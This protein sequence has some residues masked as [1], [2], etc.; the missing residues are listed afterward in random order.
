MKPELFIAGRYIAARKSHNIINVISGISA[1]GLAVGTAALVAILSVY[2][3]FDLLVR[4]AMGSIE[5]DLLVQATEGKFF[6]IDTASLRPALEDACVSNVCPVVAEDVY[7]SYEGNGTIA[8]V[9]GVDSVFEQESELSSRITDGVFTLHRSGAPMACLGEALAFRMGISPRFLPPVELYFPKKDVPFSITA[10]G[11]SIG[12]VKVWPAGIFS[13]GNEADEKLV[14]VPVETMR[15][16]LSLGD[17]MVSGIEIRFRDES[18][19]AERKSLRKRLETSLGPGYAVKDR[20][21]QNPSLYRMMKYEKLSIYMILAFVLAIVA[22]NIFGSLTMLIIEK[23]GDIFT[24]NSFGARKSL[25]RRIFLFEGWGVSMAGVIAGTVIGIAIVFLQMKTGMLKM[26]GSFSGT[27]YPVIL[28]VQD[29]V[30]SLATASLIGFVTAA[31][32]ALRIE[33]SDKKDTAAQ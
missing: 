23:E 8:T 16:L 31:I 5:P 2:N 11:S 27:P 6:K 22:F 13:L 4:Q 24:M 7:L 3:G 30:L 20:Y 21:A 26:P 28:K 32:P 15:E 18:S 1:F 25:I 12:S 10:P 17:D 33:P 29:I 19:P 14:T 9:K